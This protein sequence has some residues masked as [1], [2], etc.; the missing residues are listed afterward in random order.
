MLTEKC[1][2]VWRKNTEKT[3]IHIKIL[4]SS[5]KPHRF[6][7]IQNLAVTIPSLKMKKEQGKAWSDLENIL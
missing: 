1:Q 5:R 2:Y 3:V 4:S 7:V 6:Y